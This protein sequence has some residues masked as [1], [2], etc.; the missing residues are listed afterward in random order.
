MVEADGGVQSEWQFLFGLWPK[1]KGLISMAY[2]FY[3]LRWRQLIGM[4]DALEVALLIRKLFL[5]VIAFAMERGVVGD[6]PTSRLPQVSTENPGKTSDQS[7]AP[8]SVR[9]DRTSRFWIL[10]LPIS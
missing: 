7:A 1:A 10:Y 6:Y 4:L 2:K 9:A 3:C 5:E 8:Q